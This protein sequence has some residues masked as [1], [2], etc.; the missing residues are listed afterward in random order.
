MNARPAPV[1]AF[2]VAALGIALFSAMDGL[3]KGLTLDIG[4]Y[5]A[6][7]WRGLAAVPI[8]GMLYAWQRRGGWPSRAALRIHFVRG[9]VGAVM[10][11]LFFWGLAYVPLAQGVALSFI[12][13]VAALFLAALL[14]KERIGRVT[15]AATVL[16]F[17]GVVVILTG[18]ARAELG[19]Q[20]ML[21]SGAILLSA[22]C[23]AWNII[24]MRQQ[25]Q[26]AGPAEVAFFQSLFM[27]LCIAL[28][29]PWFA[30]APGVVHAPALIGSALLATGSLLLLGWAYSHAEANYLAPVEYTAFIWATLIGWLLF[31]EHVSGLTVIGAGMIVTGCV[32]SAGQRKGPPVHVET[33]TI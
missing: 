8:S 4:A 9:A 26:I 1:A 29:A 33:A 6:L 20:A 25:A 17:A 3:M 23:Y 14:L 21:G 16:A 27:G 31:D 32:I 18:Q 13:P 30:Q 28:A 5:N 7:L 10:A 22:L 24:L 19:P 15:V 11:I 12:A 2:G